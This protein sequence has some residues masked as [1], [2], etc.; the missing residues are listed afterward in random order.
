MMSRIASPNITANGTRKTR[1]QLGAGGVF[2]LEPPRLR[3]T[4]DPQEERHATWFE[5]FFDLVFVAAVSQLGAAL[6]REPSAAGFARFAALFVIVLWAWVLYTL[7]ANRFDT[8]DLIYRLAKSGG[9]LAIAAVAVN[10]HDAMEGDGG[11]VGFAIG[12]V[13]LRAFL[14][15]LY[16]RARRHVSGP[17]HTLSDIYIVGYSATTA[18]WL[19][20]IFVP[21]PAR[22]VLWGV[23]MVID[24]LIPT[25]AW[26]ALK[27][28]T[29]AISHLTE[30]FGIFFIIVL[31]ESV[32]ATVAGVAELEF[33]AM[34]WIVA[35]ICFVIALCLWWAYFDLADTSVVGR[36]ALGLV[37]VY[38]HFPLLAGVA[39]FGD[40][41][42]LAIT[43]AT[44]SGLGAGT[45]W[46][47]AGGVAA[48]ALS[49][50]ALHLGAEWT[51]LRD[52]SFLG[53]VGLAA[54]AV[55]LAAAGGGIAPLV[56]VALLA[57]A[58]VATLLV[59]AFSPRAGAASVWEPP[60]PSTL[61]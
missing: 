47:L 37:F 26:A 11:T 21:G 35:G 22:Y 9:M 16:A 42:R 51:S 50:A 53:R 43:E 31:G 30:R 32:V 15:A 39:A 54:V 24:L 20:S 7:Y 33:T 49:L 45:R 4:A 34:S 12:Y 19:V 28:A 57:V 23:A 3:T 27:G 44:R 59:D 14:I 13:A 48:F 38:A 58:V 61:G 1:R 5:L 60:A 29:V 36:G 17:A 46:A 8:D 52:R 55:A 2:R 40:G 10:I 25:R 56:F 18:L 6:A 41:T